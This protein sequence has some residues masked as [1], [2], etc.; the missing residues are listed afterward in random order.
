[1]SRTVH[2]LLEEQSAALVGRDVRNGRPPAASRRGWPARRLRPRHRRRRQ[3]RADRGLRRRGT[4]R[5]ARPCSSLTVA[6]IEPTERGFLDG[7]R[8]EDR[9]PGGDGRRRCRAPRRPRRARRAHP[10][11][12]RALPDPRSV[13]APDLRAGPHATTSARPLGR[14]SPRM[15]GWPSSM[16]R[17]FRGL[18][19]ENLARVRTP[20]R[21]SSGPASIVAT[22]SGSTPSPAV[23]RSHCARCLGAC[24]TTGHRGS[25]P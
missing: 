15:T 21:F 20:R 4:A 17:L 14:E 23:I 19:L 16:G 7:S 9:Q 3:V 22:P 1:M 8:G 25:R 18:P 24:R 6:R 12:L 11:H 10:G 2:Q 5:M 13:A